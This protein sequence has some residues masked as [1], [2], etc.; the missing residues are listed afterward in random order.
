MLILFDLDGT[1]YDRGRLVD[2]AVEAV[3]R[4]RTQGHLI[5]F[6]TNTD[7]LSTAALAERV[8]GYGLP[9]TTNDLVT[10]VTAAQQVLTA[11]GTPR[12]LVL[13]ND[14]VR[15]EL[16]AHCTL[17]DATPDTGQPSHVI[18][19]DCQ[20]DLTY[21]R[22]DA[23]FRAVRAGAQL[24]ALQHGRYWRGPDGDHL[25][26]GAIV[27]A[28]EYAAQV[29]AR[30]LGKPSQD[31][32]RLAMLAAGF[33]GRMDQVL[34]VGDDRATDIRMGVDAGA[35]TVQVSTGKYTDQ[36]GALDLPTATAV[37]GSVADVPG[38][39]ETASTS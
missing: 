26:T 8:R 30:V 6:F 28:I 10:P 27:A 38:W 16:R 22:L 39:L 14:Q 34:I 11:A 23:A 9:V 29:R 31:F 37:L 35:M 12:A 32:L 5:R 18:V 13:G 1:V 19:G 7:S 15:D 25:D 2:G 24:L 36:T 17:T 20:H 4:L 33:P 3:R 21:Q